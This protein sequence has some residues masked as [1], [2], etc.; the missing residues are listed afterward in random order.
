MNAVVFR[1]GKGLVYEKVPTPHPE[2]DQVLIR[3]ANTGFCGSDHSLVESGSLPDGYILG[4]ETSG[5]V[6]QVGAAVKGAREGDR[7]M[8]R[9]TFCHQCPDCQAGRPYFCQVNRRSIGIGDLGGGFAEYIVAYP[10]MLIPIPPPV[11]S[12]NAAL[13]EA[14]AT[15]LHAITVSGVH[16]G[17]ALVIGGGPI[18]L[19]L[20]RLLKILGWGSVVLS[21]PVEEKRRLGE[22]FGADQ[23]V[24][25]FQTPLGLKAFEWT[26]GRM[27][28]AVFE[29]SGAGGAIQSGLDLAGR[30]ASVVVVSVLWRSETITPATLTFKEARLTA[31]YSNT[32]E[33]NRRVLDWMAEGRLDGHSLISDQISLEDLPGV[34][35]ERIHPGRS[36][37]VMLTIGPEF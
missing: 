18:G 24:D 16:Q 33:E 25:P 11:D 22:R 10:G 21:E 9:P 32:H 29:C 12:R 8:I 34:Y 36:L 3:V 1:S 14:F 26:G 2:A 6:T 28:D 13:A 35:R 15:S 19:A 27:F 23:V 37:K 7:V 31:S 4:H 5:V 30:G 20:V 17:S